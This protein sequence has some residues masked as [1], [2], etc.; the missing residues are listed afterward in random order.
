M[1]DIIEASYDILYFKEKRAVILPAFLRL[2][3]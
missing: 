1:C 2:S 3:E